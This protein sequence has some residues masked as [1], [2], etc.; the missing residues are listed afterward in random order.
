HRLE[1]RRDP[2]A[3]ARGRRGGGV[4]AQR[5]TREP[6]DRPSGGSRRRQRAEGLQRDAGPARARA[7]VS[8]G[9]SAV[10]AIELTEAQLRVATAV[11]EGGGH[12]LV[13]GR[14]GTGKST[15][16]EHIVAATERK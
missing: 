16:L 6:A 8:G 9:T 4:V 14:A 13:T 3:R 1:R 7:H 11:A 15:L 5:R 2:D 10:A 12:L